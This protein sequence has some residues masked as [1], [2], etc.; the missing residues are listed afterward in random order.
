MSRASVLCRRG[1]Y[2]EGLC[3]L[4]EV[5]ELV[6][7]VDCR[8]L[9]CVKGLDVCAQQS[10]PPPRLVVEVHA[11]YTRKDSTEPQRHSA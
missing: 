8:A 3:E 7:V 9:R 11:A 5:L 6:G 1:R 2:V 10:V 4:L